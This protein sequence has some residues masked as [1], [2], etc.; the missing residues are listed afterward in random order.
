[1]R[2]CEFPDCGRDHYGRGYCKAHYQ[3]FSRGKEL[4]PLRV[5]PP[6]PETCIYPDCGRKHSAC[7]YCVVHVRQLRAGKELRPINEIVNVSDRDGVGRK[8][9]SACKRW[10]PEER[11]GLNKSLRDG[12]ASSCKTCRAV[13]QY[14]VTGEWYEEAL[15][16]GCEICQRTDNLHVDHDHA[17]CSGAESCGTC[18][19]GILCYWCNH[20]LGRFYDNAEHLVAAAFYLAKSSRM[21]VVATGG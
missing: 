21:D 3:Q 13:Q 8:R 11:F 9:C 12:L 20:G 5:R 4:T 2:I 19:R 15:S 7:G 16:R 14:K 18:V 17:C 1:M 6:G 10:L